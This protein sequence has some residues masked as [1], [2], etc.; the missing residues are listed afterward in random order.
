M[1]LGIQT[2]GLQLVWQALYPLSHLGSLQE[3]VLYMLHGLILMSETH[4]RGETATK[5]RVQRERTALEGREANCEQKSGGSEIIHPSRRLNSWEA[6]GQGIFGW[7]WRMGQTLYPTPLPLASLLC[8]EYGLQLPAGARRQECSR[9]FPVG[10]IWAGMFSWVSCWNSMKSAFILPA[11]C[12]WSL[13]GV[14]SRG[15]PKPIPPGLPTASRHLISVKPGA[16]A[17]VQLHQQQGG[18]S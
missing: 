4:D 16:V 3:H 8:R 9:G 11:V 12:P 10:F 7:P 17:S 14:E 18:G 2:Q 1:V 6:R 13:W 5:G 15:I